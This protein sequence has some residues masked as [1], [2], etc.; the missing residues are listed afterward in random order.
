MVR[1]K[2]KNVN[3]VLVI[4]KRYLGVLEVLV[5]IVVPIISQPII[6]LNGS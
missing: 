2:P 6:G 1:L 3:R 4:V 5:K